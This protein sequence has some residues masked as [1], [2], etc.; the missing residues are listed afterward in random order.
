MTRTNSISNTNKTGLDLK[1]VLIVVNIN[2]WESGPKGVEEHNWS[3]LKQF[4]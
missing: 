1:I 3:L 2:C 4:S